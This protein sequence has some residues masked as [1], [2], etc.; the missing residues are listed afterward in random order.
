MMHTQ[1][2]RQQSSQCWRADEYEQFA[3]SN[4]SPDISRYHQMKNRNVQVEV[5]V[6]TALSLAFIGFP[7]GIQVLNLMD[8]CCDMLPVFPNTRRNLAKQVKNPVLRDNQQ[9]VYIVSQ[10]KF[11]S[12]NFRLY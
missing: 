5:S 3:V 7:Q 11:R 10:R 4:T 9:L 8:L 2:Q 1:E 12:S 6:S